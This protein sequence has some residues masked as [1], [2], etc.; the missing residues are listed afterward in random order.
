VAALAAAGFDHEAGR[1][2]GIHVASFDFSD[3]L[4]SEIGDSF[5]D[6]CGAVTAASC[7]VLRALMHVQ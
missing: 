7:P 3:S 2:G 6:E 4:S 5:K 1:P